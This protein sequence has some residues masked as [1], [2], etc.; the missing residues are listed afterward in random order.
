MSQAGFWRATPQGMLVSVRLTP[1]AAKDTLE[2]AEALA[3]GRVVLKARVRAVPEKGAAN[4]AL[5]A[6]LA[7]ALGLAKSAVSVESG[8][9]S[10]LKTVLV[11]GEPKELTEKLTKLG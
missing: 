9:T 3:D 5:E 11:A 2:G 4:K 1:K 8:Q 7:K 6:L 10:R